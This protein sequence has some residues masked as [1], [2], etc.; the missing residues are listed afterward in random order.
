METSE[1]EKSKREEEREIPNTSDVVVVS[2]HRKL[3]VGVFITTY[4]PL[5]KREGEKEGGRRVHRFCLFPYPI[6]SLYCV[7]YAEDK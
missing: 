5:G 1:K 3:P 7:R 6:L 2:E 4:L